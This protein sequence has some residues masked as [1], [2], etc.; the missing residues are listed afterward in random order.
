MSRFRTSPPSCDKIYKILRRF[1]KSNPDGDNGKRDDGASLGE[2]GGPA[3]GTRRCGEVGVDTATPR[4]AHHFG[5]PGNDEMAPHSTPS[6]ASASLAPPE[7]RGRRSASYASARV[8]P[9]GL[10]LLQ[11]R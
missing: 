3:G 8:D 9:V 1:Q 11:N 4:S 10:L 7:K 6:D 5:K 2:V